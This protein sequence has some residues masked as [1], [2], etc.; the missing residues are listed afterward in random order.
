MK[1]KSRAQE[2]PCEHS[3]DLPDP[4]DE[5]PGFIP[6]DNRGRGGHAKNKHAAERGRDKKDRQRPSS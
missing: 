4:D 1:W 2:A 3:D 6:S 5:H